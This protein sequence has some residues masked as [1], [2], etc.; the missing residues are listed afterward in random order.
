MAPRIV[1]DRLPFYQNAGGAVHIDKDTGYG[2]SGR[3]IYKK[4]HKRNLD[5]YLPLWGTCLGMELVI[6]SHLDRKDPRTR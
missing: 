5:G 3:L 4:I 2:T 1:A 6:Y